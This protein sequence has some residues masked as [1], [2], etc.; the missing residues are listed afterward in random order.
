M[1]TAAAAAAARGALARAAAALLGGCG[2]AGRGR[3]RAV[4]ARPL[5]TAPG[6]AADMKSYLWE[7]YREAKR[8]TDGECGAAAGAPGPG[9][10]SPP[11]WCV[12]SPPKRQR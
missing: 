12:R 5:C 3:L 1:A 7:R 2:A 8:S 10:P 11:G 9:G 4:S 6:T